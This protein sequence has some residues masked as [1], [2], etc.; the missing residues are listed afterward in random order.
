MVLFGV[1]KARGLREDRHPPTGQK[2]SLGRWLHRTAIQTHQVVGVGGRAKCGA[3]NRDG[4]PRDQ[5]HILMG[6]CWPLAEPPLPGSPSLPLSPCPPEATLTGPMLMHLE[7][8]SSAK[9][10]SYS[11]CVARCRRPAL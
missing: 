11:F 2:D 4:G 9:M 8:R 5:S 7:K 6:V 10:C 1:G 3:Q